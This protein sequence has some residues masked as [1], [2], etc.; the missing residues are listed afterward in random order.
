MR[1]GAG[2]ARPAWLT[3]AADGRT[4]G[5]RVDDAHTGHS[6]RKRKAAR[7]SATGYPRIL[8]VVG[9]GIA[10]YKALELIRLLRKDGA[11]MTPVLT[12]AGAFMKP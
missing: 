7:V 1:N 11:A 10:A 5:D 6:N 2:A 9:G 12:K 3:L 4:A 8:L